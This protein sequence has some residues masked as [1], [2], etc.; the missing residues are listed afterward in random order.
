[1]TPTRYRDSAAPAI[2]SAELFGQLAVSRV[3]AAF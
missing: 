2:Q 1:M 3:V